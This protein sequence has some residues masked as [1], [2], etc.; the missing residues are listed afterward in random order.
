MWQVLGGCSWDFWERGKERP[1]VEF[2]FRWLPAHKSAEHVRLGLI[3]SE[4][5]AGNKAADEL[6]KKGAEAHRAPETLVN[7]LKAVASKAHQAIA[8]FDEV[9]RVAS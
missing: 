4:E 1:D 8:W 9:P 7:G 5:L 3:S 2:T 6:A